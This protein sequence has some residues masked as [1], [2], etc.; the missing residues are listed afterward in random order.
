MSA[1]GVPFAEGE[2]LVYDVTWAGFR[3]GT[4][5]LEIKE[6]IVLGKREVFHLT[7]T[8][9]SNDFISIFYPV[10]DRIDSYFDVEGL[11]SH[12]IIVR[13]REGKRRRDKEI[14]FDQ[15]NRQAI[16]QKNGEPPR[17]F[18]IPQGVQDA[19]SSL[20]F[21]R[22]RNDLEVGKS[23]QVDV[24]ENEKNFQ[25]EMQI[26]AREE[27]ETPAGRFGAL[28]VQGHLRYEGLF[29]DKGDVTV[30]FSDDPRHIPV[31]MKSRIKIGTIVAILSSRQEG[32]RKEPADQSPP[33]RVD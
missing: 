4:A 24:H 10:D 20:Y 14:L 27:I 3:A 19:L 17:I 33:V 22:T 9:Q 23:V 25:V 16:L 5:I 13:Q 8:A 18:E 7:S 1:A 15:A 11:Y 21:F 12:Q 2:R 32:S 28:K 26:V 6:R 30:W 29:L 31:M